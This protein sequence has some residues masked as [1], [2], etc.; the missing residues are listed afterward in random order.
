MVP[1]SFTHFLVPENVQL[2][3]KCLQ[4]KLNMHCFLVKGQVHFQFT[5]QVSDAAILSIVMAVLKGELAYTINSLQ[6]CCCICDFYQT[7]PISVLNRLAV[8]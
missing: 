7:T 8:V 6:K 5:F 1:L 3:V 4:I 2:S